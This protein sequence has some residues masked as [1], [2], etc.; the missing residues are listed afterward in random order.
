MKSWILVLFAVGAV[1]IIDAVDNKV[2]LL[3]HRRACLRQEGLSEDA[4]P[5]DAVH[6][7]FTTMF[8]LESEQVPYE[9]K[10]FLRCW[11]KRALIIGDHFTI[12]KNRPGTD[13]ICEGAARVAARGD[14]CEFA[15]A[16]QKCDHSHAI[17]EFDY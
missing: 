8:Q 10:C 13:G 5:T 2:I 15:F 6:E 16:Y 4:F 11:L 17:H 12:L 14:E 7:I 1:T 9:T 3:H